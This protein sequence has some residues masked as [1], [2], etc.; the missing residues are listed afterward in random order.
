MTGPD[1]SS[2][3]FLQLGPTFILVLFF[4]RFSIIANNYYYENRT[5]VCVYTPVTR[6]Y[7]KKRYTAVPGKT[8]ARPYEKKASTVV[9]T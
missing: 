7:M 9:Y 8:V 2:I 3:N 6:P 4:N 1:R 5:P